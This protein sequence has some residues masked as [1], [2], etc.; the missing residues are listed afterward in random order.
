MNVPELVPEKK[1]VPPP[2]NLYRQFLAHS[3]VLSYP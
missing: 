3:F 1:I 2:E